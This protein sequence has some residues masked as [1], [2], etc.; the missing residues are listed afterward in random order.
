[1]L[2]LGPE[3]IELGSPLRLAGYAVEK[4]NGTYTALPHKQGLRRRATHAGSRQT[5]HRHQS[6]KDLA[7]YA[8][9]DGLRS[10]G[11]QLVDRQNVLADG[12][13]LSKVIHYKV[14]LD[15]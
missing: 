9:T 8:E 11:Y 5:R 6:K 14:K 10:L 3:Y 15:E 4:R 2:G 1:M 7:H 12:K 13:P